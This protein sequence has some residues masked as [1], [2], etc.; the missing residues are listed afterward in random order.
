MR[1]C[2]NLQGQEG[3][4]RTSLWIE[5]WW[6]GLRICFKECGTRVQCGKRGSGSV[7]KDSCLKECGERSANQCEAEQVGTE[8]VTEVDGEDEGAVSI[9]EGKN[10]QGQEMRWRKLASVVL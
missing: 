1:L 10:D 5:T 9:P 3:I 6:D 8:R 2:K 4:E 7:V